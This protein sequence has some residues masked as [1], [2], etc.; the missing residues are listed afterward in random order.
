MGSDTSESEATSP[1]KFA[2]FLS[3]NS[4]EKP[5][6]ERIAEK[7]K[8]DEIEPWLDKWCLTPGADWQ[9]GLADGL[10]ESSACAVFI[11]PNGIGDWARLEFKLATDRMAKDRNFRVFLVLLPELPEPFDTSIL[12]PFLT[13]RTWVDLRKGISDSRGYQSLINAVKGLASGPQIQ[14]AARDDICPYRGLQP[15]DEAHAEFFF[16][17]DADIQ[18]LLEKLKTARFLSVLGPSGSGKSSVVRAGLIPTIRKGGLPNS[19]TW[20]VRTF[21]PGSRPLTALAANILRLYPELSMGKVL[22]ELAA[23]E[24]S[25]HL[26]SEVA[27]ADRGPTEH[28]VWVIDQ[29]EEVFTLCHDEAERKHFVS[30]LLYAASIPGG[31][32]LF[33]LTMRADFYQKCAAY[34]IFSALIT[35]HQFLVSP[36][37]VE[38][39]RTAIQEPAWRVGLE[40]EPGLI[41]TILDD[42][43]SQP[44]A[45]PLLEHALMEL[46]ER[47]RGKLLTLEAY[48]ESGGVEGAIAKRADAIYQSFDE[49]QRLITRRVMLRLTQ[50][51]E[52]TEDTRRRATMDEL[53]SRPEEANKVTACV[54]ALTDARL[55]TTNTESESGAEIVDVSHEALIRGWPLLRKWIEEDRA[56]L[57]VHRRLTEA[58]EEWKRA[59]RDES[60][61]FR[62]ARLA[63][64]AEW[65]ERNQEQLNDLERQ[66]LDAGIQLR[67]NERQAAAKRT[68]RVVI[69][70]V[71]ALVLISL[72]SIYA[73]VQ[74]RIA[75]KRGTESRARELAASAMDKV[76]LN[77]ELGLLLAIEAAKT[78]Q[79]PETEN[80]LR[81]ALVQSPIRVLYVG[82][83]AQRMKAVFSPDSKRIMATTGTKARVYDL[84]S[85][86]R[87]FE[88]EH[89][90]NYVKPLYSPDG[91]LIAT[92]TK[93][94]VMIWDARNGNGISKWNL[95]STGDES[96][97]HGLTFSPDSKFLLLNDP[98]LQV[99]DVSNGAIVAKLNGETPNFSHDAKL[100]MTKG[101][102]KYGLTIYDTESWKPVGPTVKTSQEGDGGAFGDLSDDGN[103]LVSGLEQ[104][105]VRVAE[106]STKRVVLPDSDDVALRR[107][108]FSPD[109][110]HLAADW[111]GV[112]QLWDT[113]KWKRQ[114]LNDASTFLQEIKF[115]SDSRFA[116]IVQ[117]SVWLYDVRSP[118][119]RMV[120]ELKGGSG[121]AIHSADFSSD[122]NYV[123]TSNADGTVYVWD[124]DVWRNDKEVSFADNDPLTRGPFDRYVF[125]PSGH[126]IVATASHTEDA[127]IARSARLIEAATGR[128]VNTVT[129]ADTVSRALFSPDGRLMLTLPS[130]SPIVSVWES[131]SG[132][133]I[134]DLTIPDS[135]KI[136]SSKRFV[137]DAD[138]SPDS[139]RIA[140]ASGNAALIW[141]AE[142]GK[143]VDRLDLKG[144]ADRKVGSVSFRPNSDSLMVVVDGQIE[145]WDLAKKQIVYVAGVGESITDAFFG[146][147]GKYI[148]NW[149][150]GDLDDDG[151]GK[152]AAPEIRDATNGRV[153][154]ELRGH[155]D[156]VFGASFS[157]DSKYL[158]TTG[159]YF[160]NVGGE[161]GGLV[162][163][164][165]NEVR[166][167]DVASGTSFYD[168]K[169]HNSPMLAGT[170]APDGKTVVICSF[171]ERVLVYPCD[172]CVPHESLL[173][174][175]LKRHFRPFTSDERARYLHEEQ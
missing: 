3:H 157:P 68:R 11:G 148:L 145:V 116:L 79:T 161:G 151:D 82:K 76:D 172:M 104:G 87:V 59:E 123:L 13:T 108:T 62:G 86:E 80:A 58:A 63:Q 154:F 146:P 118:E 109:G 169:G 160:A 102:A 83:S 124:M 105:G 134:T 152:S 127:N 22:D 91:N 20:S 35:A 85:G 106:L 173:A 100:V 122:G 23:D 72:A 8:R 28:V 111:E 143:L 94:A 1:P 135:V 54:Q 156:D 31:R 29:F 42:I 30:N 2:V 52:G 175:A 174:L 64:T 165:A 155:S 75:T 40:F 38:G 73:F 60:L 16:G 170:F 84:D 166:V 129:Q 36:M 4:K 9:D 117:S 46:W 125:S 69:G 121:L 50:P 57:R 150:V 41:D 112:L 10:S 97:L 113:T 33:V 153:L 164:R 21:T 168:F 53:I 7:L 81:Q 34:P 71:I 107:A 92:A 74:S 66:F 171:D 56:G 142:S 77:P 96:P 159:G 95:S 5:T 158:V 12:P 19:D 18:R 138:F 163:Y 14:I 162:P 103:F 78:A 25:L 44:G 101:D 93:K 98:D 130:T 140:T 89:D 149:K 32:N 147:N 136:A 47:R 167:W 45:L 119:A 70:L 6:V 15:F 49:E 65:R 139:K 27:L 88:V 144:K 133:K 115:S 141:E 48:R 37:N 43:T 110:K 90:D 131:S 99:R 17:R 39:L 24:R 67:T 55:L 120:A 61:L 26:T 137:E 132:R 126:M 128:I 114:Q 51:G